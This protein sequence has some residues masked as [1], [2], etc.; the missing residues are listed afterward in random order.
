MDAQEG[1]GLLL[2]RHRAAG[3]TQ[4]ALADRSGLS[5]GG[6]PRRIVNRCGR[7]ALYG[8]ITASHAG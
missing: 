1:F 3:L 8:R 7:E 6:P 4:E 2:R 5:V